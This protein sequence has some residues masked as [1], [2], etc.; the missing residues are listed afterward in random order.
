VR[1][2]GGGGGLAGELGCGERESV[3]RVED[4]VVEKE[5]TR[6]TGEAS[7]P[8]TVG[9]QI[10]RASGSQPDERTDRPTSLSPPS[11]KWRKRRKRTGRG[12]YR[13]PTVARTTLFHATIVRYAS[14][15]CLTVVNTSRSSFRLSPRSAESEVA[16]RVSQQLTIREGRGWTA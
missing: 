6:R 14:G 12:P 11:D 7:P 3:A 16:S 8:R 9:G 5:E 15:T 13:K 1:E 4:K 2:E 10:R